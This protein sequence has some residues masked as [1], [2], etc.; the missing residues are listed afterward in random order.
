MFTP[1]L[2]M[3]KL[4]HN[5][6]SSAKGFYNAKNLTILHLDH[7]TIQEDLLTSEINQLNLVELK[8][9]NN[10]ISSRLKRELKDLI[11]LGKILMS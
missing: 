6:I 1:S 11:R 2:Q 8:L 5:K 4:S 9:D 10:H 7:N 3:I